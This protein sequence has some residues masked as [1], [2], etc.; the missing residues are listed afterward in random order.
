M[1][2]RPEMQ[3]LAERLEKAVGGLIFTGYEPL[4][5]SALKTVVP[6]PEDL[7]GCKVSGVTRRGKYVLLEFDGPRIAF[8]LSQGGRVDVEDPPKRTKGKG[9]VARWKF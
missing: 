9:Y 6:A 1:P 5:F 7:I 3:A 8:H 2:E 4:Q